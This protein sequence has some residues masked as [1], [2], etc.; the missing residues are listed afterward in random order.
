VKL[1]DK[2]GKRGVYANGANLR[3]QTKTGRALGTRTK[4][5]KPARGR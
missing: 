2:K 3:R 5:G 1:K 4:R